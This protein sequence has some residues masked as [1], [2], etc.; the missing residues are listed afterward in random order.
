MSSKK[1]E[2]K[3]SKYIDL[4]NEDKNISGQKFVCLSFI[5]P[6]EHIKNRELY[7]FQKYLENFD[8]RKSIEK[9][10]NFL[11]FI[12]YKYNLDPN[13]I[14]KDMDEFIIE[15]KDKLFITTIEDDYKTFLDNSEEKLLKEFNQEHNFQTSTRG[16][17]VR[18]S[19]ESQEEAEMKC[20]MLREED[21]DHDVYLGHVGKWLPFHPD[22]YKTGKVEYLEKELNELMAEKKKNDEVSKEN[23]KKRVKESKERAINENIEKAEKSG[24]RLMQSIDED[25]NLINADRMDVPGKN[26]LF[27]NSENDDVCTADLRKE[28]FEDENVIVGKEENNDH[29]LSRI[30]DFHK[31]N[32]EL[33]KTAAMADGMEAV[34]EPPEKD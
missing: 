18:G 7:Y 30:H 13:K 4:L 17:K 14:L 23:F 32:E 2:K 27:G 19:F 24:N 31:K 8:M 26:L 3:T 21:P 12:S 6:E 5:S 11:N 33:E 16:V 25:G 10:H 1:K 28:L 9:F 15:E 34:S 29:G 20:K 22:A